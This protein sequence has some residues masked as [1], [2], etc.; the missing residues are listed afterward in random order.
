M[1]EGTVRLHPAP[2]EIALLGTPA[3]GPLVGGLFRARRS[4]FKTEPF[5]VI[6]QSA[7]NVTGIWAI[8]GET[9]TLPATK[10]KAPLLSADGSILSHAGRL[11][12][13]LFS[14]GMRTRLSDELE[15]TLTASYQGLISEPGHALGLVLDRKQLGLPV[16]Y[17][18]KLPIEDWRIHYEYLSDFLAGSPE[19]RAHAEKIAAD[20]TAPSGIR[21][22]V[23]AAEGLD[24]SG[25]IEEARLLFA[26][27]PARLDLVQN[28]ARI[29]AS[30]L[31]ESGV[32]GAI[33]LRESIDIAP[34]VQARS[35]AALALAVTGGAAFDRETA[36]E[37]AGLPIEVVDDLIDRGVRNFGFSGV[38]AD[39]AVDAMPDVPLR[40]YV[41][42]RIAPADL[43]SSEVVQLGFTSEGIRRYLNGDQTVAEAIPSARLIDV[44][45]ARALR[46]GEA[47]PGEPKDPSLRELAETVNGSENAATQVLLS[48]KSVWATLIHA[49]ITGVGPDE[50]R[51]LAALHVSRSKLFEWDWIGAAGAARDGLRTAKR[52]AVRDELL[53]VL[54][55]SLWMQGRPEQALS[56]LDSALEGEY[57]DALLTNAAVVATELEHSEAVDRFVRLAEEAVG[58][59]QRALAAE[60][61]LILWKRD[62]ARLWEEDSDDIP[63]EIIEVLRLL[64]A[65]PIDDERYER[66]LRVLAENDEEWLAAQPIAAFGAHSGKPMVRV[67]KARAEGIDKFITALGNELRDAKGG[68]EPWVE[69]ERDSL[70]EAAIG[71]LIENITEVGAAVF[72]MTIVEAKLPMKPV[73]RVPLVC[74]TVTA[75]SM[76]MD[77]SEGE[78]KDIFID[79]V[80]NARSELSS[81]DTDDRERM[82]SMVTLA[83]ESLARSY[84]GARSQQLDQAVD[85]FNGI[86]DKL[87]VIPAYQVNHQAVQEL[88]S[89]ISA[90]CRESWDILNKVR[91]LVSDPDL[92]RWVDSV[93]AHASELGNKA[94]TIR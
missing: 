85:F 62:D 57:S 60:K 53:N 11:W 6:D 63:E 41:R 22:R 83:G 37:V 24:G 43:S 10:V 73:Q 82:S 66:V 12:A 17:A 33:E 79:W 92:L 51:N 91:P 29:V 65:E 78:P 76:S 31:A 40:T 30:Y 64:I 5:A 59:Q 13:M 23:A 9:D 35:A 25:G 36:V 58:P 42:A 19:R 50:L 44:A 69:G 88:M 90:L 94:V 18:L 87:R 28:A 75:I 86:L 52:E 34:S 2:A 93:M 1:S 32:H 74:L 89:P 54:A 68:A 20:T 71:V 72:G 26:A 39:A 47:I 14:P 55:C 49:G 46:R 8:S 4:L 16:D 45:A 3:P 84:A 15:R 81:L 27:T 77:G 61:A 80:L 48:D 67:L 7:H 70:V 38:S 56:A 21:L